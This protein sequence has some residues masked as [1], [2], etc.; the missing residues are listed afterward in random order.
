MDIYQ[1]APESSI[2]TQDHNITQTTRAYLTSCQLETKT[3]IEI[4][5]IHNHLIK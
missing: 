4:S 2:H 1:H 3:K 5:R